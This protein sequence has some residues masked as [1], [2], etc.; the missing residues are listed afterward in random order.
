MGYFF[1]AMLVIVAVV[2]FASSRSERKRAAERRE[3]SLAVVKTAAAEDVTAFGEEVADLDIVTA[4]VELSEGGRQ[5][6]QRALDCYD[7]AKETLERIDRAEDIRHVTEALEDGRY[8]SKCVRA[9]VEGKPLPVRRPPCFFNPQHGPSVQDIDWAPAGG[10][11]RPVP[12][13][14]A[15][16][17]RVAVGAEP[18]VRKVTTG[19]GYTR[20]AYWE[21][22][23]AYAE[24]NRGYFNNYAGSGMLPGVLMGAMLMGG[25][26]GGWGGGW[27]GGWDS[28]DAG[29][30]GDGG[31][32]GGGGGLGD[33]GGDG[34]LGDFGGLD[35]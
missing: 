21:A 14:A 23:P 11:L 29:G 1:L 17:E 3:E 12:V 13:C 25:L 15:D 10:Q 24:Y 16:A 8:A 35:F 27:D 20:R 30:F 9:R 5:D 22:G 19:D 33:F 6:Y 18:A 32:F 7:R 31:G 28:A 26:G 34:G 2:F 4:G